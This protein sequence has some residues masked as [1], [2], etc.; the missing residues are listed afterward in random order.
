MKRMPKNKAALIPWMLVIANLRA[1]A[2]L[3]FIGRSIWKEEMQLHDH[4]LMSGAEQ[5]HG[6]TVLILHRGQQVVS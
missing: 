4:A 5:G 3:P 6:L 2:G 1:C